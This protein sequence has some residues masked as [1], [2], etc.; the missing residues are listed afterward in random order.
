MAFGVAGAALVAGVAVSMTAGGS[1]PEADSSITGIDTSL[2][3]SPVAAPAG[4]T[5]TP[6]TAP[7]AP[8]V[9][10]AVDSDSASFVTLLPAD[11]SGPAPRATGVVLPDGDLVLTAAS[12]V[13]DGQQL[14]V[15]TA[16]GE[17]QQ[18]VVDG[19]DTSS[20]VAVV[21][22]PDPLKPADFVDETVTPK[23]LAVTAC[24]CTASSGASATTDQPEMALAM[25]RA[26]GTPATDDGGPVL[27]DAIEAE[28]PI[29][30]VPWGT[31]LVDDDGGVIGVLDGE[32]SAGG[33]TFGY[34]VPAALAVGVAHELAEYHHVERG[35]LGVMCQ[36]DGGAGAAV[37]TVIPGSPA[38]A[39]GLRSGDVVEAVDSHA[40]ASLADL[41]GRLY[42]V[43]P[44]TQLQLTILR[45]GTV[46][47]T[48]VTVAAPPS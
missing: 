33:D 30:G 18:G 27:V 35:W 48:S 2:I 28:V 3:T 20:G 8:D 14:T 13:N 25:V 38:S 7:V 4:A 15:V 12:A 16:S 43:P 17:R 11:G 10:N 34:F 19:I 6:P 22:I 41:Q 37:T 31:A 1:A 47:T 42:A 32:R 36:D 24:R 23:E 5:A 39:A 29:E 44:G 46:D 45:Q 26:V 40:V 9:V 21:R